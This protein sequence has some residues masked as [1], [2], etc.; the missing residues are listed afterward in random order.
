MAIRSRK[1][2]LKL[3]Q[4]VVHVLTYPPPTEM[5]ATDL[6]AVMAAAAVMMAE[7]MTAAVMTA[8]AW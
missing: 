6:M 4:T 7:A 3:I 1:T 5:V 8:A 2:H